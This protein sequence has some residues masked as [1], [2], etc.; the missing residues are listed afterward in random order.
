MKLAS[1]CSL[2]LALLESHFSGNANAPDLTSPTKSSMGSLHSTPAP[3]TESTTIELD[4]EQHCADSFN[5]CGEETIEVCNDRFFMSGCQIEC[6]EV[7]G[8]NVEEI[9]NCIEDCECGDDSSCVDQ[10]KLYHAIE[11]GKCT[12]ARDECTRDCLGLLDE[13]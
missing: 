13:V 6:M 8:G 3:T 5:L 12:S 7:H 4:C 9:D 2:L 10:Q 1:L 11:D